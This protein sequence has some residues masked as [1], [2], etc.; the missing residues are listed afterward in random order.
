MVIV[1]GSCPIVGRGFGTERRFGT[2]TPAPPSPPAPCG[3]SA[4]PRNSLSCPTCS[5]AVVAFPPRS[6]RAVG[7][8]FRRPAGTMRPSDFSRPFAISLPRQLPLVVAHRGG[9]EISPGKN[10]ELHT[11]LVA[12]THARRTDIGVCRRLSVHPAE[13]MPYG[14]SLSLGSMLHLRLPPDAPSRVH[15]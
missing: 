4:V 7:A 12:T 9:R 13:R 1:G 3:L 5:L 11:K 6:R 15:Q 8:A 14:A 2:G 10:A